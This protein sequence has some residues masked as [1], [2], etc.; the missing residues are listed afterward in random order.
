MN[1]TIRMNNKSVKAQNVSRMPA[2]LAITICNL[3]S[4]FDACASLLRSSTVRFILKGSAFTVALFY[5]FGCVGAI[6]T[7]SI[8]FGSA[9]IRSAI[10]LGAAALISYAL[11]KKDYEEN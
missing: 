6:E 10:A 2:A 4:I 1:S 3:L 11:R 5:V 9:V 8:T 7:S